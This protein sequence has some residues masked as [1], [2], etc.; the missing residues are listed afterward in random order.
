MFIVLNVWLILE[1]MLENTCI[2][3]NVFAKANKVH[4]IAS[5]NCLLSFV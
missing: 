1:F 5:N 2:G 3:I 4:K